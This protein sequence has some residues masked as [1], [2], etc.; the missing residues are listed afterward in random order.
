MPIDVSLFEAIPGQLV[1]AF[2]E[3]PDYL[4]RVAG[5]LLGHSPSVIAVK[6]RHLHYRYANPAFHRYH[7]TTRAEIVGRTFTD[8][9][10]GHDEGALAAAEESVLETRA[11]RRFDCPLPRRIG[12]GHATGWV[13]ALDPVGSA[14]WLGLAYEDTS[15]LVDSR[16]AAR[17]AERR[18]EDLCRRAEVPLVAFSPVGRVVG[19]N[20]A[21][22]ERSGYALDE[23]RSL[24][25]ADLFSS[26][27]VS[28]GSLP[29]R[30]LLS[31]KDSSFRSPARMRRSDGTLTAVHATVTYVPGAD[32]QTPRVYCALDPVDARAPVG[33]RPG[34][35]LLGLVPGVR[36]DRTER[37]VIELLAEGKANT[38]VARRLALSRTGL[39]Y[40]LAQL[41]RKLEAPSR[42]AIPSRAY[43]LG[44]I[45]PGVWP[46]R[47]HQPPDR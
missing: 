8:L 14:S 10:P 23:L 43:A 13:F 27:A 40:R 34:G 46:P 22:C 5:T 6:D 7:G 26:S 18:Y 38:A 11:P 29:W 16:V 3:D 45:E 35:P 12:T 4:G 37:Q 15:E 28:A 41:R 24:R 25:T 36:L 47:V 30:D 39:D 1:Q 21:Y 44:L 20:P 31:G 17:A 33:A 19:A 42:A 2:G 9:F 32:T